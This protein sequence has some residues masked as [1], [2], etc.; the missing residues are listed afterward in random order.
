M[1]LFLL[2]ITIIGISFFLTSHLSNTNSM[3]KKQL[4]ILLKEN[5]NLKAKI[6]SKLNDEDIIIKFVKS[7]YKYGIIASPCTL[8]SAPTMNAPIL[9]ELEKNTQVNIL[10]CG[11]VN[12]YVWYE[13]RFNTTDSINNKGWIKSQYIML[14]ETNIIK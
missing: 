8:Y 6:D 2:F 9:C 5:N 12:N 3:Q 13:V 14:F 7:K 4:L 11:E 10:D 1:L